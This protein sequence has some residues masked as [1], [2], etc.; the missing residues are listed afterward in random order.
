MRLHLSS[1]LDA[2]VHSDS[3]AVPNIEMGI[4]AS[5]LDINY[6]CGL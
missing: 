1:S 5:K 4:T 3:N 6:R 2:R